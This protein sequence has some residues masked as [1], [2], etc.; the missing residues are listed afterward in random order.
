MTLGGCLPAPRGAPLCPRG[1]QQAQPGAAPERPLRP[2]S[3]PRVQRASP[4]LPTST[5]PRRP[6]AA[7][8]MASSVG[9][10]AVCPSDTPPSEARERQPPPSASWVTASLFSVAQR[11]LRSARLPGDGRVGLTVFSRSEALIVGGA[12]PTKPARS[13]GRV[14]AARSQDGRIG[15]LKGRRPPRRYTRGS[16]SH[17]R[18]RQPQGNRTTRSRLS[19]RFIG[20]QTCRRLHRG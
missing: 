3:G 16:G 11:H 2:A 15:W 6:T 4:H 20:V 8:G 13:G 17:P 1:A 9:T 12:G 18:K 14:L 7:W 10:P 19:R 5:G